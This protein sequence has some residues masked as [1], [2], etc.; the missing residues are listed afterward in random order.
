VID[1]D[2][3]PGQHLLQL[4][5]RDPIAAVPAHGPQDHLAAEMVALEV[6]AHR[7]VSSFFSHRPSPH[8]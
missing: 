4:A 5:V 3:M 8:S 1:G 7:V 6:V 2:A